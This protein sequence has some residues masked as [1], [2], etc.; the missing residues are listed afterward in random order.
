VVI[1]FHANPRFESEPGSSA[2]EGYDDL[3]AALERQA[4]A[5][6]KSVMVIHGDTH[7]YRVDRPLPSVPNLVQMEVLGSPGVGWTR[8]TITPD[9]TALFEFELVQ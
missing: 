5:F 4:R 9:E 2:R 1:A 8:V 7:R 3:V 6:K